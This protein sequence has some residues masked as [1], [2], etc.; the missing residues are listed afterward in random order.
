MAVVSEP[1][2]AERLSEE[3]RQDRVRDMEQERLV[4]KLPGSA[5]KLAGRWDWLVTSVILVFVLIW[6]TR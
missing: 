4:Q 3:Y 5:R 2:M 6:L 1:Y